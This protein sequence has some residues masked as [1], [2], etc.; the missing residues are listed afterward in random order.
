MAA[1]IVEGRGR[2][3][4]GTVLILGA[5]SGIGRAL[6]HAYASRGYDL[7]VTGREEDELD[8]TARDLRTR[9]GVE[10][11]RGGFEAADTASHAAF[12]AS[13]GDAVGGDLVGAVA[14][15]GWLGEQGRASDDPEYAQR[16]VTTNLTGTV[17]I[18]TLVANH[19]E[20]RR[21][22]FI[23]GI[24]SVAGDRGR[25]SNYVYG[26]AKGGLAIFLQGLRNRLHRHG[27]RVVTVK[28]G[29]VATRMTYG[30]PGLFLVADPREVAEG[31]VRAVERGRDVV[32]LPGF[33]RYVMLAIRAIPE[34]IFKRLRL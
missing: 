10:V 4:A 8:R 12:F 20:E 28:P 25:Q 14:A 19:L 27:V 32:Y 34:R 6:A 2:D 26:A 13:V 7:F 18:L 5:T 1:S 33:W 3:G 30:L 31:I 17:S 29:F 15:F 9:Y 21:S 22:G 11:H 24:G 23:V 16:V